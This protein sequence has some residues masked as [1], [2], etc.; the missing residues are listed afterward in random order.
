VH[1]TLDFW[2]IW[3]SVGYDHIF[4]LWGFKWALCEAPL[5]VETM[6]MS[7]FSISMVYA[8]VENVMAAVI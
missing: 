6:G 7:I 2:I 1:G 4:I 8:E 5:S 3:I